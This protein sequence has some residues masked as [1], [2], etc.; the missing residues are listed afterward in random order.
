MTSPVFIRLT[1]FARAIACDGRLGC[2]GIVDYRL[3]DVAELVVDRRDQSMDL[4]WL[5]RSGHDGRM[6]HVVF[7]V[8]LDRAQQPRFESLVVL[9]PSTPKTAANSGDCG[10][11]TGRAGE[12][13]IGRGPRD[14]VE[15]LDHV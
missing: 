12:A 6:A 3:A 7:Q 10:D 11:F 2:A 13:M 9:T 5:P 15:R 4:G 1:R 14:R 8:V